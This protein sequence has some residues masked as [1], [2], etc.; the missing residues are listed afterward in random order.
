MSVCMYIERTYI[1]TCV[2]RYIRMHGCMH[3]YTF[4]SIYEN[5]KICMYVLMY[6]YIYVLLVC[7][8]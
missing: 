5:M 2:C 1:P 7:R 3:A 8:G 6:D 4:L